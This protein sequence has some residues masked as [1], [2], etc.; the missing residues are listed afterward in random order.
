MKLLGVI[1]GMGTRA[2]LFFINKLISGLDVNNDQDFPEFLLHNNS[3]IPDRTK[4]IVYNETSP[5]EE[6]RRSIAIMNL[7]KV[8][9][10][11]FTCVTAYYFVEKIKR[12]I[13]SLILNP[14]ELVRDK[15]IQEYGENKKVGVLCTT[16]TLRSQLFKNAFADTNCRLITLNAEK[17]E[18]LFMRSVYMEKGFKSAE[19]SDEAYSLLDSSVNALLDQGAEII[20]GGC[21][22]VQIGLEQSKVAATYMDTMDVLATA[23]LKAIQL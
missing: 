23:T 22:E 19:I 3:R 6:L 11:V 14:V 9:V 16:G 4:A 18:S 15:I 1:S 17:Q 10:M 12:D 13:N 7:A 5:V 8:E 21:S 2:G 20:I